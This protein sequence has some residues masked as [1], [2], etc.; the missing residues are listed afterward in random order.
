MPTTIAN[1][2]AESSGSN[3]R[4]VRA[5]ALS[6]SLKSRAGHADSAESFR[7]GYLDHDRKT[8]IRWGYWRA[9]LLEQIQI[10]AKSV[11]NHRSLN[12]ALRLSLES[13]QRIGDSR[14]LPNLATSLGTIVVQ[15]NQTP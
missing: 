5:S 15:S 2:Q 6:P 3:T 1:T 14:R 11:C 13:W 4:R 10:R 12:Q 8:D 9:A 7:P